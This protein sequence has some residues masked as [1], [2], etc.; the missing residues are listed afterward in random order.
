M[1][2]IGGMESFFHPDV[3][4]KNVREGKKV[5]KK[6]LKNYRE[7]TCKL[8]SFTEKMQYQLLR[9][10]SSSLNRSAAWGASV[11]MAASEHPVCPADGQ[12]NST[13]GS[14]L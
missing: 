12:G 6:L 8:N 10:K 5:F 9:L 7:N 2:T 4:S 1:P 11:L 13:L 14:H 3:W